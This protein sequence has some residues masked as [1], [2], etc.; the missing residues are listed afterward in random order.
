MKKQ[1]QKNRTWLQ[2]AA[3]KVTVLCASSLLLAAGQ[4]VQA[5]L[6]SELPGL[7][8]QPDEVFFTGKAYSNEVAG[9]IFKYRNYDPELNRWTGADPSGFPDGVNNIAYGAVPTAQLDWMGLV[10]INSFGDAWDYWKRENGSSSDTVQAGSSIIGAIISSPGFLD[11]VHRIRTQRI[12]P[13]LVSVSPSSEGGHLADGPYVG[14][15]YIGFVD[16]I[17]GRS[18]INYSDY[19]EWT[20]LTNFYFNGSSWGRILLAT[21]TMEADLSDIWNFT[22]N[23]DD[24]WWMDLIEEI[25]PGWI[26]GPGTPFNIDGIF[27]YTFDTYA[28]Q[29]E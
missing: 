29:L 6:E 15:A 21:T 17:I 5:K 12:Q 8:V 24:P 1:K 3:H 11:L 14:P 22:T 10:T 27:N 18:S 19:S 7:G 25:I 4:V 28:W 2:R 16:I 23:P 20:A 13:Q 9:V 26:A